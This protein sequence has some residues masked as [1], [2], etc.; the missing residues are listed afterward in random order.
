[1]AHSGFKTGFPGTSGCFVCELCKRKTRN[2]GQVSKH[3]CGSCDEWTMAENSLS[4]DGAS[5]TE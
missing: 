3:L 4:D 2:T 1:M 5:M